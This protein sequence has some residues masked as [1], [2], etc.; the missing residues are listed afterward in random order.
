[1]KEH[2]VGVYKRIVRALEM[3][4][5]GCEGVGIQLVVQKRHKENQELVNGVYCITIRLLQFASLWN[6]QVCVIKNQNSTQK[7]G[8]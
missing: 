5:I 2:C 1:M 4:K 3:W 8:I 7:Y 6:W